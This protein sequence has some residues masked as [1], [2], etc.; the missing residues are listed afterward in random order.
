MI[1][2]AKKHKEYILE[3]PKHRNFCLHGTGVYHP[4]GTWCSST[5]KLVKSSSRYLEGFNLQ[6][7]TPPHHF[8]EV[9]G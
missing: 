9:N 7:T 4:P 8:S 3:G 6:L 1:S 2:Q 5:P